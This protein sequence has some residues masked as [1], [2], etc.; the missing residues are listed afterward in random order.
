[1]FPQINQATD[2][3]TALRLAAPKIENMIELSLFQ[4]YFENFLKFNT[5]QWIMNTFMQQIPGYYIIGIRAIM[6]PTQAI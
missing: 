4:S 2:T 6:I 1:M 3:A 5:I